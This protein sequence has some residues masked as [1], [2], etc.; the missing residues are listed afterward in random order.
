[1]PSVILFDTLSRMLATLLTPN[2]GAIK[3]TEEDMKAA[4]AQPAFICDLFAQLQNS[5]NPEL[6]HLLLVHGYKVRCR[7]FKYTV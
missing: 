1:M 5:P 4:L 6:R 2:S 7:V 3:Q